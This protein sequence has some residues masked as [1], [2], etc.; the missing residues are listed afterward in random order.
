LLTADSESLTKALDLSLRDLQRAALNANSGI[1][2]RL[3]IDSE[4]LQFWAKIE[5][6]FQTISS[7]SNNRF[8]IIMKSS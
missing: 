1:R 2:D 3:S 8:A 7:T 5:I 6:V 4:S